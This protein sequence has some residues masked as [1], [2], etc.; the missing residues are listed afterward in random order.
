MAAGQ[1][2]QTYFI[3]LSFL[4]LSPTGN[5]VP[6]QVTVDNGTVTYEIEALEDSCTMFFLDVV[7]H[8]HRWLNQAFCGMSQVLQMTV[9]TT[10]VSM[11]FFG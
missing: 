8:T 1:C 4:Q 6:F 11:H 7:L 2:F 5:P 9:E 10:H 3:F